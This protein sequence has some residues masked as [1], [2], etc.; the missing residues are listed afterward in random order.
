MT[1]NIV[2]FSTYRPIAAG[3]KFTSDMEVQS[4]IRQWLRQQ[5]ASF[6]RRHYETCLYMG[7]KFERYVEN[8]ISMFDI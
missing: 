1:H 7:Y 3:Q 2:S 4:A 5:T 8:K 6:Y